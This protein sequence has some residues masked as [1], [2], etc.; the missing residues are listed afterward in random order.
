MRLNKREL[1]KILYDFNSYSNRLIQAN[2]GDYTSVLQKYLNYLDSTPIIAD[3]IKSC[4]ECDINVKEDVKEVQHSYGREIFAPGDTEE[5]EVRN[6]YAVLRYIANENIDVYDAI[7]IGY[8]LSASK[9]QERVKAF[10]DR[11]VMILIGHI[12]RYLTKVGIDMGLDEKIVYNVSVKNGQAIIATD[13]STVNATN[14]V[15]ADLDGLEKLIAAIK[16]NA[17]VLDV[18]SREAAYESLEVIETESAAEKPKKSMIKTA[19][20][21][22]KAIKGTVEFGASVAALADFIA[23]LL[24]M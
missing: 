2:Y 24:P 4:G 16:E 6:I 1:R 22:L 13:G 21:T 10:N 18:D 12:E 14:Q 8:A 17:N 7:A 23:P 20:G 3:Y 15:K 19:L 9:F 11:F 5:E